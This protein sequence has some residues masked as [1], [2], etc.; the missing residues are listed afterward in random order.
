MPER[1]LPSPNAAT[2][3][4]MVQCLESQHQEYAAWAG[5]LHGLLGR[6]SRHR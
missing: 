5:R 4:A 2:V 3:A 1:D 6:A